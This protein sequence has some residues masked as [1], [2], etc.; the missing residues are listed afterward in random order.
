MK[1]FYITTPIYYVN[2]RP[3]MGHAYSTIAADIIARWHRLCGEEVFFL[4]GTD[5][6][7]EKIEKAAA[8]SGKTPQQFVDEIADQYKNAWKALDITYDHFIRTTDKAHIDSVSRFLK[9]LQDNGDIY[10]G[11][12][13][14][15]YCV[16]DETF[17]TELQLK[18]GKCPECGREVERVKEATH[19]FRLSKYQDRL[20]KH[21]RDN[22]EFLSPKL[23]SEEIINRVKDGLKDISITRATVKWGVRFGDSYTVYVWVDAL[24]N[25]IS[26]LGWPDGSNFRKFWPA[27]IHLV[28]KEINWFHSVIWPSMLMS[29]NMELPRKVFATGW[30][31]VDGRKMSK[32]LGNFVDPMELIK[33]Y[34][35]DAVRYFLMREMPFGYDGDFSE[36]ALKEKINSELVADLGNLA[37]RVLTL[38]ENSKMGRFSGEKDLEKELDLDS[39]K[40]RMEKLELYSALEGIM[41]FVKRCNKYVNDNRPWQQQGRELER[42]LYN[43][44]ESLRVISILLYPFMPSTSEKLAGKLGIGNGQ[45]KLDNC[46]FRSSF[47][48]KTSKGELLFRKFD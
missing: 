30:W 35:V 10:G 43:L 42:T 18:D 26:A 44:L 20:L 7:G 11:E 46:G 9:I 14:G 40:G 12:Y 22:P 15:W 23:R 31:T 25:Y 5:E 13:E 48:E 39:I 3:H 8:A 29:A 28:G 34:P 38:V 16:P 2:D 6:H 37:N 1:G 33:K 32:S 4:T 17:F 27:E 36:A 19:F 24:L 45:P 21:Y 47:D 41:G